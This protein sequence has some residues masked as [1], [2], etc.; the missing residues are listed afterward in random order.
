LSHHRSVWS[1]F[2]LWCSDSPTPLSQYL[3]Y[4][5]SLGLLLSFK[6]LFVCNSMPL[7]LTR[8]VSDSPI[9]NLVINSIIQTSVCQHN[10]L[11]FVS[12]LIRF[13]KLMIT[14]TLPDTYFNIAMQHT[15][16][17]YS[18]KIHTDSDKWMHITVT[19]NFWCTAETDFLL[20]PSRYI[21]SLDDS[22][23]ASCQ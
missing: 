20:F 14:S 21:F 3:T 8:F 9:L 23:I 1:Y 4:F 5:I 17:A 15:R 7:S 19:R 6:S 10:L 13:T 18:D 16:T 22:Y 11:P 2:P 12:N